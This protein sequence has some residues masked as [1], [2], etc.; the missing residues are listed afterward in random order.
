MILSI[1]LATQILNSL[2]LVTAV[3]RSHVAFT[4]KESPSELAIRSRMDVR[5]TRCIRMPTARI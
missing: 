1:E 2:N 5:F 3:F 4:M